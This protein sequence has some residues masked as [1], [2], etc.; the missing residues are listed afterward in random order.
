[1][2]SLKYMNSTHCYTLLSLLL[3]C[4]PEIDSPRG[5][6]Y[7]STLA[8]SPTI[9]TPSCD[10]GCPSLPSAPGQVPPP[11]APPLHDAS[12]LDAAIDAN[13][14]GLCVAY[15]HPGQNGPVCRR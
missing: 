8:Y 12:F 5:I 10:A 15:G 1:M 14:E 3:G 7:N 6:G 11:S 13:W 2:L 4:G 9:F